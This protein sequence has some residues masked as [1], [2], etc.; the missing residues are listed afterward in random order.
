[1]EGKKRTTA[2]NYAVWNG[3]WSYLYELIGELS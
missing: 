3:W 1:M 2:G